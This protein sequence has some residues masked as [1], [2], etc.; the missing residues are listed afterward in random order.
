M[1]CDTCGKCAER[2][3]SRCKC[4]AYCSEKCAERD[5]EEGGHYLECFAHD[6]SALEHVAQDLSE[7]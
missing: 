7:T 3:C 1:N 4:A 5:W 6:E 2:R